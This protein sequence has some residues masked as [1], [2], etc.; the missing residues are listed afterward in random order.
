MSI[1]SISGYQSPLLA[2]LSD[3][4]NEFSDLQR[5]LGSGV[6][7]ETYGGLGPSRGLDVALRSRISEVNAWQNS[8]SHVSLRLDVMN[9]TLGRIS[10]IA[11][12]VRHAA[13]PNI[14]NVLSDGKTSSQK[15]AEGSLSELVGLLNSDVAGRHMFAGRAVDA[16]PVEDLE[17]ILQG[18]GV[19]AGFE[20]VVDERR[21]ADLGT[22]E[23]GRVDVA[24]AGTTVSIDEDGSHSFGF[25]LTGATSALTNATVTGPAGA[26]AAMTVDFTGQ[27]SAGQK[28]RLYVDLPD[29]SSTTIDIAASSDGSEPNSF[30]IGATAA[31]TAANFETAVIDALSYEAATTLRAASAVQAAT[32]FFDTAAGA[33][34]QRVDGPPFDTATAMRSGA[35]DTVIWYTGDNTADDPRSSV[36]TR[37]DDTASVSYGTRANEDGIRRVF[38][39]LAVFSIESFSASDSNDQAR[40][41]AL[42]E[43][44]HAELTDQD[45]VQNVQTIQV[46]I[47][48]AHYT[49][50]SADSRHQATVGTLTEMV[51]EIE[52]ADLDEVAAKLVTLQTRIQASY[53][54]TALL[55]EMSLTN[56]I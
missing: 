21:Q 41:S 27:P 35:A 7:A 36:T 49:V 23:Q 40:Y 46:E 30:A 39:S 37:I 18:D 12:E 22:S 56:F 1:S 24:L 13:D 38:Q 19:N 10:E 15:T 42:V 11:S 31:D 14:Y 29:G 28:L 16:K 55:N 54:A 25:K 6:R 8:I 3:M 52:R 48:T 45:G 53:Q 44:V 32:D 4:R 5:Q 26:P 20:Q 51:E 9:T 47:A 17:T 43:R 50:E 33:D 34:P 2:R